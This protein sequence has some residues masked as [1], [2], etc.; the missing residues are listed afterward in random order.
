MLRETFF[1]ER[2]GLAVKRLRNIVSASD[3]E[4]EKA[5]ARLFLGRSFLE[6]GQY[7][8]SLSY[9]VMSDVTKYFPKESRFWREY[10]LSRVR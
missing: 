10:A 9:F 8:E 7:R 2:Y 3:N 1:R 5:K 6:L 4:Y